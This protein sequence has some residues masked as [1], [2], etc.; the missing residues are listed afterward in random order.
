MKNGYMEAIGGF[1]VVLLAGMLCS[2]PMWRE[3][4]S[5]WWKTEIVRRGY[6]TWE[7][8]TDGQVWFKWK[9]EKK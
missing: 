7:V 5:D 3:T 4:T 2:Y 6:G 1:S 8:T 9:E